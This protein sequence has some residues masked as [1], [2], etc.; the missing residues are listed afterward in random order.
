MKK[1]NQTIKKGQTITISTW[2]ALG[3]LLVLLS[4]LVP[5]KT[6]YPIIKMETNYFMDNL[7][8]DKSQE[9]ELLPSDTEFGMVIPKLKITSKIIKDVDPFDSY[10]Y[11]NAL[12]KG[13]AHAKGSGLPGSDQNIFIFSHSSID[14][15]KA[16]RYNSVFY[17]LN[18]LENGD[19]IIIY[20]QNIPY[21]YQVIDKQIVNPD[22]IEYLNPKTDKETLTLMTCW[23]PGSTLKRLLVQAEKQDASH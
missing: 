22:K 23:P 3:I 1:T 4:L 17:L 8:Q 14:F 18:K 21:S 7:N 20:Y 5:L 11:Q 2:M 13:V 12:T 19:K 16:I 9:K 10:I 6:F 15:N